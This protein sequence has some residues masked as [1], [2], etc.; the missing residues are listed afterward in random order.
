MGA[1][2]P[3]RWRAGG[4]R[5]PGCNSS[6]AASAS[7]QELRGPAGLEPTPSGSVGPLPYPLGRAPP[8]LAHCG[9]H[10]PPVALAAPQ[11][12]DFDRGA[13]GPCEQTPRA[14]RSTSSPPHEH[15][16][17]NCMTP[18]GLEPAIPGSVG[19]CLIHWAT[20]PSGAL[21]QTQATHGGHSGACRITAGWCLVT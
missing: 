21:L 11:Q 13:A 2:T 6:P 9:R 15:E 10:K 1:V 16:R 19:Q 8:L 20:G 7:A 5:G 12:G 14:L 4:H 3:R 17:R 18:A